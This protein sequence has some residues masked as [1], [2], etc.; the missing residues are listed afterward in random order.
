MDTAGSLPE[1]VGRNVAATI[2]R[3]GQT[4]FSVAEATGIPRTTLNRHIAGK[5]DGFNVRQLEALGDHLHVDPT[6]FFKVIL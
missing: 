2:Q 4:P 3:A 5:G 6:I 1:T